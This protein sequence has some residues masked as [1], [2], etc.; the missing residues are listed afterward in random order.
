MPGQA[1]LQVGG[2]L[3]QHGALVVRVDGRG[4]AGVQRGRPEAVGIRRMRQAH[5]G[6]QQLRQ[7]LL[8][9]GGSPSSGVLW[10]I[11][12]LKWFCKTQTVCLCN[13]MN[14]FSVH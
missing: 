1:V 5:V 2:Q 9:A 11:S 12:S 7:A 13:I 3:V 8:G 14:A 4:A 10:D 6:Q